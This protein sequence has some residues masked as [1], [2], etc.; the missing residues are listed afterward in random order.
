MLN[1][2]SSRIEVD[3]KGVKFEVDTN[4]FVK[5]NNN[6]KIGD[7]I[8]VLIKKY[9]AEWRS[10]HGMIIGFDAFENLPTILIAYL[11]TEFGNADIT[12]LC[13]NNA[14]EGIEITAANNIQ[15]Q[16]TKESAVQKFYNQIR[17][18]KQQIEETEAKLQIFL[19]TFSEK[20]KFLSDK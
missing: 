7:C 2:S 15:L 20:F 12:L 13:F 3:I 19:T 5:N 6:Y 9:G 10:Y 16:L 11:D 1:A 14:S 17:D 18:L 4:K 8:K